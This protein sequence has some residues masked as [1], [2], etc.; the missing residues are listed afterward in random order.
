M[1]A[2]KDG[3]QGRLSGQKEIRL[4]THFFLS[5]LRCL[6]AILRN[7]KSLQDC[8]NLESAAAAAEEHGA[9]QSDCIEG[10]LPVSQMESQDRINLIRKIKKY[11]IS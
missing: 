2:E 7:Q 5:Q 9:M 11:D 3:Q 8:L 10:F 6:V 4:P 1:P